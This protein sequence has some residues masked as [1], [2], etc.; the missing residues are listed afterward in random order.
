MTRTV[1]IADVHCHL[2]PVKGI[3]VKSLAKKFKSSGGWYLGVVALSPSH[4]ELELSLK[5]YERAFQILID[6]CRELSRVGLK[7]RLH[8][9]FHPAEVDKLMNLGLSAERTLKLGLEVIDLV[10][11]M[12][13]R[14]VVHGIG[15]VGVQHYKTS[16]ERVMIAEEIMKYS[17]MKAKDL[18]VPVHLHLDQ[19]LTTVMRVKRIATE[20]ECDFKKIVIHHV[21][22]E[23]LERVLEL[24]FSTTIVGRI[25]NLT[26]AC[27][28]GLV[29]LVESD[30]LDDPRRPGAVIV[31]WSICRNW[32][33]L[34]NREICNEEFAY[35]VNVEEVEKLYGICP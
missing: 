17:L 23:L 6:S 13:K 31:P 7:Y 28:K 16:K 29:T 21:A 30:Y 32:N 19:S 26:V 25:N 8:L 1:P 27:R 24:G 4:M 10:C 14:G 2:N 22:L 35:K 9:G 34:L 33:K 3:G 15:E 12:V 11:S 20:V 18:E 5:G